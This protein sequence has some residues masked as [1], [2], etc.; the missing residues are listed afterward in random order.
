M[1]LSLNLSRSR[2]GVLLS[3]SVAAGMLLA[4]C[5]S[6]ES[7]S[8]A[9]TEKVGECVRPAEKTPLTLGVSTS[10]AYAHMY[11]AKEFGFFEEENLDVEFT[12]L[13]NPSDTLPLISQG[14]I[15]GAFG[16]MSAGFLNAVDRGLN[17]RMVQA[18]G[19]YP[20]EA[21]KG[22][23]FLVR[24]DLLDDGTVKDVSDLEG[25]TIG[26][27][28][29]EGD[30]ANAGGYFISKILEDGDL[31]LKDIKVSNV[32]FADTEVAF[33]SKAI[34]AAFVP[35]PFNTMLQENGLA[36]P[37]G[38]QEKLAEETTG[39]LI[40]GPNL[41]EDNR[42]AGEALLRAFLK[43]ADVMREGD[44]RENPDVVEALLAN[45]YDENT[46]ATTPLYA[47]EAG[48]PLNEE[49]FSRFQ[50]TFTEY[51]DVL[52]AEEPIPFDELTDEKLREAA[53]ATHGK[54]D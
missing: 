5:S 30:I 20:A 48:L 26:F 42:V 3:A 24:K 2:V 19:D 14:E 25:R 33:K 17:I 36:E 50:E 4:G 10:L 13:T 39:G 34:D 23:A 27:N 7:A 49:S 31:T 44:Y 38:D 53:V 11:I 35:S 28:G 54:C 52:T 22:A 15:D 8:S 40:L 51:G 47:Y 21:E 29:G 9:A 6:T 43:A 32:G 41:L 45:E 16:G 37:F 1:N 18:R 46:I 12:Q